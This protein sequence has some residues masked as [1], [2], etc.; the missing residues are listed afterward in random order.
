VGAQTIL[1]VDDDLPFAR[2]LD[3]VLTA[4]GYE[5]R[6]AKHGAAAFLDLEI[7]RPDLMLVDVFMPLIDGITLC[8][9]VRAN[10]ATRDMPIV[11]M[12]AT[13]RDIPVPISGF[14]LKPL[15]IDALLD[16]VASLIEEPEV[17]R[18]ASE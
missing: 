10:P 18:Q 4:A 6:V 8:L 17:E 7:V 16:L 1:I 14:L 15:D 2:F 5:T 9:M 3:D 11:V 12:S 13:H